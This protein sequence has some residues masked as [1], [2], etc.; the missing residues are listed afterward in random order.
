MEGRQRRGHNDKTWK[1]A[2]RTLSSSRSPGSCWF[3]NSRESCEGGCTHSYL[4]KQC[5]PEYTR[6][7]DK[8][9]L[10]SRLRWVGVFLVLSLS[11]GR[12]AV[13]T[14]K[15]VKLRGHRRNCPTCSVHPQGEQVRNWLSCGSSL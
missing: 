7:S 11:F 2:E 5:R 15:G 8:E 13:R 9:G 12:F 4:E 10:R 3:A 1:C 6:T 14:G